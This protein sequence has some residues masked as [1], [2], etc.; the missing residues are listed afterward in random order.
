[1]INRC[2]NIELLI[3]TVYVIVQKRCFAIDDLGK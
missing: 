2:C 3:D 1:M